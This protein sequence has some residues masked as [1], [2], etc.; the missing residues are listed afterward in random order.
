M[1]I[2]KKAIGDVFVFHP[3]GNFDGGRECQDMKKEFKTLI[4]EGTKKFVIDFTMVRFLNSNGVG[5]LIGAKLELDQNGGRLVLCSLAR[6]NLTVLYTMQLGQVFDVVDSLP[7]ALEILVETKARA[8]A[9]GGAEAKP[10][11]DRSE[12]TIA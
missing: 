3:V 6:R 12:D 4:Q 9:A 8:A 1:K 11:E 5:C 7:E 10:K 2:L